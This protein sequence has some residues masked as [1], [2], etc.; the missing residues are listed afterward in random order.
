M[1]RD[2]N[3]IDSIKKRLKSEFDI[4]D[5]KRLTT[6]LGISVEWKGDGFKLSQTKYIQYLLL[7][8]GMGDCKP[9][10]LPVPT[11]FKFEGFDES[12]EMKNK[13]P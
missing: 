5:K 6:F 13:Q 9:T 10:S 11:T 12:P 3:E 2:K 7:E 4:T 8:F 1:S